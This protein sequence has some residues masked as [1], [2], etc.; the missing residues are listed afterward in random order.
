MS[1][2]SVESFVALAIFVTTYAVLVLRNVREAS[3]PIWLILLLGA[4]AM[5]FSGAISVANAYAAINL[6]VLVFLFSMFVLV[7]ALDMSGALEGFAIRLLGHARSARDVLYLS[8][9]GFSFLSTVLMN[10]TIALMGTP[11]MISLARRLG[12]SVK[13]LLLTLAFAVTIGST[14]TPMGNPQNLLIAITSGLKEP[15]LQFAYYLLVPVLVNLGATAL[16][17]RL[18]FGK[19]FSTSPVPSIPGAADEKA[20]VDTPLARK[21]TAV[22]VLTM[23]ALVM[24]NVLAAF[25][26]FVPFGISE[27]A[28]FGAALLLGISGKSREIIGG[29]D[30]GIL[31]MFASLFVLMQAVSDN[32]IISSVAHYLPT[33]NVGDPREA[34]AA[35]ITS[36]V[37]LSQILSN[38][39]MVALYLPLM[40]SL[41]FGASSAYSWAALAGGSTLAG[42]L[43]LLGAASNL[44]IA[45][46]AEKAGYRLGFV[47]FMKVGAAVT[48]LNI[49]V[50][51]AYLFFV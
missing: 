7:K 17:L 1:F 25:G 32:G 39:P 11:I 2:G 48:A 16:L 46:Q 38:V 19:E 12:M 43:T 5:V 29:V 50:L 44:I 26:F 49:A 22:V 8:F 41:G 24:V 3:M 30:W 13:P 28:L 9:F 34:T 36:S 35:I 14:A 40:K 23:V 37:V 20:K 18:F 6:Q 31:V 10:D 27:V 33:I 21:A 47:E 15:I 42:N 45:E 51:Y 4:V